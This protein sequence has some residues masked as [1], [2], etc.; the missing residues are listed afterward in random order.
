MSEAEHS[1][2]WVAGEWQGYGYVARLC[3]GP[4]SYGI[5]PATLYKGYGR[6]ATLTLYE[7]LAP[8]AGGM[9]RVA[10]FEGGWR[11]GRRRHVALLRALVEILEVGRLP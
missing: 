1:A 9:R 10:R 2:G 7:R 8:G 11:F 4:V 3:A 5:D 6:V